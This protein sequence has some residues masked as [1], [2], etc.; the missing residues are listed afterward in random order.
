[1]TCSNTLNLSRHVSR[2]TCLSYFAAIL[3]KASVRRAG[4]SPMEVK[5]IASSPCEMF[6]GR[7][8]DGRPF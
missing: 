6:R 3:E 2:E 4:T 1:L 7:T 5:T 8:P